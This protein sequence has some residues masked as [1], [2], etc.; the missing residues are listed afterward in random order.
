[1]KVEDNYM[2]RYNSFDGKNSLSA[3]TLFFERAKYRV[4]I[5]DE[6]TAP[7]PMFNTFIA[8]NQF[9]GK[10]DD[11]LNAVIANKQKLKL[12]STNENLYALDFV[13]NQFDALKQ[14]FVKSITIGSISKTEDYLSSIKAYKAYESL[15]KQYS[16]YMNVVL[17]SLNKDYIIDGKRENKIVDFDSYVTH[18]IEYSKLTS[19]I[20]PITKTCFLKTNF[21]PLSVSGMVIEIA[22]LKYSK[23][24]EKY[25][26][27]QSSNFDYFRN[28]CIKHGFYIDY[29]APWRLIADIGSPAMTQAMLEVGTTRQ[30]LFAT[31]F[32][33]TINSEID[34]INFILLNGY[35]T[36]VKNK[37]ISK[38][39]FEC[40]KKLA[41]KNIVRNPISLKNV[42]TKL[43]NKT[44]L[45]IYLQIRT[46]E[47]EQELSDSTKNNILSNATSILKNS[48]LNSALKHIEEQLIKKQLVGSGTLNTL[49]LN[50]KKS[51][52]EG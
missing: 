29:N 3:K 8:E 41:F 31:H 4:G 25:N 13:K 46:S 19:K 38:V 51:K 34:N 43:D 36:F 11:S 33:P 20:M 48:N 28:V 39:V 17:T 37:P 15:D 18:M 50:L 12:I 10:V 40:D 14:N 7:K 44:A 9:Y 47:Q 21:C 30:N 32:T 27:I 1:M 23:D 52:Q 6:I 5:F 35:N 26:F 42:K 16:S 22:D 49:M 2:A 24:E 45:K